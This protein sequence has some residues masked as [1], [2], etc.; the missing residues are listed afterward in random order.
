MTLTAILI[1]IAVTPPLPFEA[2]IEAAIADVADVYPLPKTLVAAVIKQESAFKPKAKSH[3]GAMGLMQLMPYNAV[4]MGL[5]NESQLWEPRLNILAGCRLLA[6]LLQH[7][8]GDVVSA[9]VA[10]NSGP[11]TKKKVPANGETPDYVVKI[12]KFWKQY[13]KQ[14]DLEK[15]ATTATPQSMALPIK[16]AVKSKNRPIP[17]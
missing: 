5:K 1:T 14:S 4:K 12:L 3:C 13:E 15:G 10:Y 7:Y 2:E 8:E 9:L 6:A 11:K 17:P 16:P